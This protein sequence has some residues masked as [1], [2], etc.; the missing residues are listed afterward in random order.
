VCGGEG[1]GRGEGAS[2]I[3]FVSFFFFR[4]R[5]LSDVFIALAVIQILAKY[6]F[7]L[8]LFVRKG[9]RP[10]LI[11]LFIIISTH[12]VLMKATISLS[13][14]HILSLQAFAKSGGED[15]SP[16]NLIKVCAC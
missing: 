13:V 14:L 16:Y 5:M 11:C 7:L 15:D 10:F 6:A 3:L 12:V 8:A 9:F 4:R 2:V 1:G